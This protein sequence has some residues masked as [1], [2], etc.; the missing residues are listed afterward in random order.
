MVLFP[1]E[2]DRQGIKDWVGGKIRRRAESLE[3]D[4]HEIKDWVGRKMRKRAESH[5]RDAK[6][7]EWV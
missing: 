2:I 4:R 5:E 1:H 7:K 6:I 3:R